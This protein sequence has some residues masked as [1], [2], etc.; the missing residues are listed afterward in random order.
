MPS[1]EFIAKKAR[2]AKHLQL[3]ADA[4][5]AKAKRARD[6][7]TKAMV[8]SG[9]KAIEQRVEEDL[10]RVSLAT[11][12]GTEYDEDA[13]LRAVKRK[14]PELYAR[15]TRTTV[16]LDFTA[17]LTEVQKGTIPKRVIDR[18]SKIVPRTPYVTITLK[19]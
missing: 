16:S 15:I 7:V 9:T 11:P 12:E 3:Q 10:V 19:E 5:A 13:I 6:E 4:I 8:S 14:D 17:L 18:N 2:L 1:Q